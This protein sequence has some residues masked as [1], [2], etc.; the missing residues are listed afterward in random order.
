MASAEPT[1]SPAFPRRSTWIYRRKSFSRITGPQL[2]LSQT[3][4]DADLAALEESFKSVADTLED[5]FQTL[6]GLFREEHPSLEEKSVTK[7][8]QNLEA[9]FRTFQRKFSD[10]PIRLSG[11][12]QQ[13]I[14][15]LKIL[16]NILRTADSLRQR[17]GGLCQFLPGFFGRPAIF[18]LRTPTTMIYSPLVRIYSIVS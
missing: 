10:F 13:E 8:L 11:P 4:V 1:S 5:N 7:M 9:D 3:Q 12:S 16:K 6:V 15:N 17:T 18:L 14:E 2:N